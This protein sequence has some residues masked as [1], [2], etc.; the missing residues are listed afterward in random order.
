[1]AQTANS[2]PPQTTSERLRK[3][4]TQLNTPKILVADLLRVSPNT[5]DVQR[6]GWCV[7]ALRLSAPARARPDLN[8]AV[9]PAST[10]KSPVNL[11]TSLFAVPVYRQYYGYAVPGRNSN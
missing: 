2:Q 11:A 6:L 7:P 5:S 3:L 8:T 10:P 9:K 4:L 1:M